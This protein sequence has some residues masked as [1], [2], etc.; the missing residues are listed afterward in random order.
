MIGYLRVLDFSFVGAKL[1]ICL[2]IH[3]MQCAVENS[4]EPFL[5]R[6]DLTSPIPMNS[7][8]RFTDVDIAYTELYIRRT[9]Y[10][11]E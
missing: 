11:L 4:M 2:E 8:R 9:V 10:G 3:A 5:L 6:D 1:D 7:S